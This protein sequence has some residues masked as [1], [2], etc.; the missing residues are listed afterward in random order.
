MNGRGP[1]NPSGPGDQSTWAGPPDEVLAGPMLDE[2]R[3]PPRDEI[4][5]PSFDEWTA[6]S[7]TARTFTPERVS[8]LGGPQERVV[9]GMPAR[10]VA[11][12]RRAAVEEAVETAIPRAPSEEERARTARRTTE[13]R[14]ERDSPAMVL[15]GVFLLIGLVTFF[16]FLLGNLLFG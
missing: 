4:D 6:V 10:T 16:V 14:P 8:Y 9:P 2:G 11:I 3:P 7:L 5:Q 12:R 15:F 13:A 1:S